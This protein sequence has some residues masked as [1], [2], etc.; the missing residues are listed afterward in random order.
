[1]PLLIA[2]ISTWMIVWGLLWYYRNCE[3]MRKR[4]VAA[5]TVYNYGMFAF[6]I[7]VL[8]GWRLFESYTS[9]A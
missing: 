2:S 9:T 5:L 6:E 4:T 1:M 8:C 3:F 7:T